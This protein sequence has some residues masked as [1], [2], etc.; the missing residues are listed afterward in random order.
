[1]AVELV[2]ATLRR[3]TIAKNQLQH[4]HRGIL[5]EVY[6]F[7]ADRQRTKEVKEV[8]MTSSEAPVTQNV[9]AQCKHLKLRSLSMML[10]YIFNV[11][12]SSCLEKD[13]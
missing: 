8:V 5:V 10:C 4:S 2:A 11:S 9:R 13:Y 7:I 6:S 3:D 1:M 12:G